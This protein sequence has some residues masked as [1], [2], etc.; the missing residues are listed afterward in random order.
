MSPS[1]RLLILDAY[2]P[3]NPRSPRN[4]QIV[5]ADAA[6]CR[7]P[8]DPHRAG[9]RPIRTCVPS[10]CSRT[11][12]QS[13]GLLATCWTTFRR[14]P[15]RR[16][17][18]PA[19]CSTCPTAA[20]RPTARCAGT[21]RRERGRC[22][23]FGYTNSGA[24]V[25]TSSGGWQG[26]VVDYLDA[27]ALRSYW[28]QV[29]EPMLADVGPLAGK[30]LEG[31]RDR[32]LGSGRPELDRPYARGVPP[33]PRLRSGPWLPVLAGRIVDS[34]DASNR[35]LADCRKT[36]GDCMADNHYG[37]MA[38]LARGHGHVHPLR[39]GRAARRPVRRPEEPRPLRR[40]D[41]RVLGAFAASAHR[42][43]AGSS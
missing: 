12:R 39:G 15:G 3:C 25:S 33:P 14:R 8:G 36:I 9:T 35:F 11:G 1:G 30:T 24:R 2:D 42:G 37:V 4:C 23:R 27:D 32:Q 10:R 26:L 7:G 13:A 18:R 38:E 20:G 16:T 41:G 17:W 21:F 29:V 31:L 5:A 6:R 19:T 34:R 22:M 28:R 40:A 43:R